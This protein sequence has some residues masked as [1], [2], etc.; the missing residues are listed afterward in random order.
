MDVPH[1]EGLIFLTRLYNYSETKRIDRKCFDHTKI[2]SL[3]P[4]NSWSE[5]SFSLPLP[6]KSEL[7]S[8]SDGFRESR[9]SLFLS[10]S[11]RGF[12][13]LVVSNL[14]SRMRDPR[15]GPVVRRK[16]F[17]S[18][19]KFLNTKCLP[20]SLWFQSSEEAF[21]VN[22]EVTWKTP[23]SPLSWEEKSRSRKE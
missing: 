22:T 23:N 1:K 16:R 6:H 2:L 12:L 4:Y 14:F 3:R 21:P 15:L 5:L 11:L 8:G 10:I 13:F 18:S 19:S 9:R 20:N 17:G 7:S